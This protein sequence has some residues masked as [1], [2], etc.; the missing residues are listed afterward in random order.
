MRITEDCIN[1][2]ACAME[3]PTDAIYEPGM[4]PKIKEK[5]LSPI[6]NEH[7][8]IVKELCDKCFGFNQVRCITICPMDAI[9]SK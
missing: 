9:I 5:L 8:F 1:C 2:G 4:I 3:C 6:S 7:F